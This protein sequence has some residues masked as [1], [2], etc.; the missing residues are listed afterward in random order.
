MEDAVHL[1]LSFLYSMLFEIYIIGITS[2][3]R[4]PLL[5]HFQWRTLHQQEGQILILRDQG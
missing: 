4:P 1:S 3:V 2:F 5:A